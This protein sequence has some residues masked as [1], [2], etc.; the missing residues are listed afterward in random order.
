MIVKDVMNP[1]VKTT[2]SD[3]TVQE[4]AEEMKKHRIGSLVVIDDSK[5]VGILTERDIMDKIVAEAKDSSKFLVKDV[6]TTDPVLVSPHKDISEAADV[7]LHNRIK[8]LPVVED[9]Q[10]IGII[11]TTDLCH[12]EP[13]MIEQIGAL[14]LFSKK[15]TMAG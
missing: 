3:V 8:K 13:K 2:T 6:M 5:L 12:A 15:R 4:A 11:T 10:I 7:M 14:M 1:D 9:K